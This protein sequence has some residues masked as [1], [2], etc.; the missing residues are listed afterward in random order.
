M[1]RAMQR[2]MT[3]RTDG[4]ARAIQ[5]GPGYARGCEARMDA[6]LLVTVAVMS[7]P[8]RWRTSHWFLVNP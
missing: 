6:F 8:G 3:A 4:Q 1:P 7:M 5:W 2:L